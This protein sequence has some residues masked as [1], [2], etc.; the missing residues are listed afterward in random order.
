MNLEDIAKKAGVS[1]ATVSRVINDAPEV[2]AKTREH[3]WT[4]IHA[5]NFQPNPAARALVRRRTEIIGL[6]VPT[7]ENIFFTD[8]NYFMQVLAGVSRVT[9]ERDYAM[10][11]W[12]GEQTDNDH[13]M[14]QKVANNRAMDGMIIVSMTHDHPMFK[15]LLSLDGPFVMIDR[16]LEYAETLSYVTVDNIGAAERATEHLISLGRRRIAHITGD[17]GI[18]DARDRLQGYKNALHRAG[19][20]IDPD[21]IV[22]CHFNRQM[23]YE[24]AMRLFPFKPDGL[25]A[26]GDTIALGVLQAARAVGIRV[27]DDLS[28]IGFDDVDVASQT[29]PT[30]TTMRQPLQSKGAAATSLLIDLIEKR[31]ENP[32][33]VVLDTELIV[34]QSCGANPPGLG[35]LNEK[36]A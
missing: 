13:R 14:M 9:R 16:P 5:E 1:R 34:R 25:F 20:P 29:M 15:R 7:T 11:L 23:G 17:M 12:L 22:E 2:N 18:S 32:Q 24:A 26:A 19:L 30:L 6:V 27:P 4:V 31:L 3:V 28:V 33:H 36:S 10:L 35:Y 8:N 21:L